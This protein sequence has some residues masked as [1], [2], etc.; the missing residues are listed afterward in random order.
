MS[1]KSG[2]ADKV[3]PTHKYVIVNEDVGGVAA[4]VVGRTPAAARCRDA[5]DVGGVAPSRQRRR[6]LHNHPSHY[7]TL[8]TS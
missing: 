1:W 2:L 4:R 5:T 3:L 8:L 6:P 7:H